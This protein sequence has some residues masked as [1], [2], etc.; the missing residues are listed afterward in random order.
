MLTFLQDNPD[1]PEGDKNVLL[2][3]SNDPDRVSK[4]TQKHTVAAL[5]AME[6]PARFYDGSD[7]PSK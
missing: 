5:S 4:V 6:N 3:S 2:T 1:F 7:M